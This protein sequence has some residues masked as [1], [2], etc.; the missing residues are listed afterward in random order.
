MF[1]RRWPEEQDAAEHFD[2]VRWGGQPTCPYCDGQRVHVHASKD[3]RVPRKQCRDCKRAFSSTVS[4]AFHGSH[5]PI[6]TWAL[7]L[8]SIIQ[9]GERLSV[10]EVGREL[11][12]PY[13]TAWALI[14]RLR[15]MI[16]EDI[17][18]LSYLKVMIAEAQFD[19]SIPFEQG[20]LV[21][22]SLDAIESVVPDKGNKR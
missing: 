17:Y 20:S 22:G 7:A 19:K 3:K 14:K 4:T 13:K 1:R 11:R 8:A 5:L 16:D 12:I 6:R 9:D 2:R 10:S 15:R 18:D 21:F